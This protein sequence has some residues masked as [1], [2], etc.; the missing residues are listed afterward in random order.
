MYGKRGENNLETP[1][2]HQKPIKDSV[3]PTS[4]DKSRELMALMKELMAR[5]KPSTEDTTRRI[6]K[7]N[8]SGSQ[9]HEMLMRR[10]QQ[11]R[12]STEAPQLQTTDLFKAQIGKDIAT[13]T[14]EDYLQWVEKQMKVSELRL[15]KLM[16][17]YDFIKSTPD[18][19]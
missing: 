9:L 5:Q 3:V 7:S 19:Q 18:R 17:F 10:E 13:A 12:T 6:A 1:P 4:K 8:N 11:L 14:R 15:L 16:K 2:I